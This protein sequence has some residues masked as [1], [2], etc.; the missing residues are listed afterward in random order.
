MPAPKPTGT[1]TPCNLTIAI[2]AEVDLRF[3][4]EADLARESV[5]ARRRNEWLIANA[6]TLRAPIA[7]AG[8]LDDR[9][10]AAVVGMTLVTFK[11]AKIEPDFHAGTRPRWKDA[12]SVRAKFAARGNKPTTPAPRVRLVPDIDIDADLAAAGLRRSAGS[13]AR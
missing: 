5:L 8:P 9:A 11:R 6:G 7:A 1:V 2:P 4:A 12:D 13:G 3:Q 10:A